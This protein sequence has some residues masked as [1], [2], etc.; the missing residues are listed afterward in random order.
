MTLKCKACNFLCS[1][2][3]NAHICPGECY[4][5]NSISQKRVGVATGK[6]LNFI[7]HVSNMPE[8]ESENKNA[9]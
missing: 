1:L 7:E 8:S 3:T 5:E 6:N 9:S 2:E 4:K